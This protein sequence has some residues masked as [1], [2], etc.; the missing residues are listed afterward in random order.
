LNILF[1]KV[2]EDKAEKEEILVEQEA[3]PVEEKK[4]IEEVK[5]QISQGL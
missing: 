5:N 3:S 1:K 4:P 2:D